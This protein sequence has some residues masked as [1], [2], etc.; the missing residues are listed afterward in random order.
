VNNNTEKKYKLKQPTRCKLVGEV[1][2]DWTLEAWST[3][4]YCA[5]HSQAAE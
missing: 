1:K 5:P 4:C 2:M 3:V